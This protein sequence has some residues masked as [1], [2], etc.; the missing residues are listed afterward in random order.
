MCLS[1]LDLSIGP[2]E[3]ERRV[4]IGCCVVRLSYS[5]NKWLLSEHQL[6]CLDVFKDSCDDSNELTFTVLSCYITFCKQVII[7]RKTMTFC[8]NNKL[9]VCRSLMNIV[10]QKKLSGPKP[11]QIVQ[12]CIRKGV[13]TYAESNL[14]IINWEG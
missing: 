4:Q 11:G 14:Q 6:G 9:W 5:R 7:H 12:G 2:Q 1:S 3:R 10:S 8:S 13:K